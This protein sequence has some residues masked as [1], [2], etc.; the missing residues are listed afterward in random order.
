MIK[1][2]SASGATDAGA[3][4]CGTDLSFGSRRPQNANPQVEVMRCDALVH[5]KQEAP[6]PLPAV[7]FL[8]DTER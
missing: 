4:R 2:A 7:G 3:D 5:K 1:L 6:F 8:G